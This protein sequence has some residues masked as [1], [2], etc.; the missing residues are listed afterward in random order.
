MFDHVGV[1]VSDY[2]VSKPFY[3]GTLA[4]L[5]YAVQMEFAE[6]KTAGF[7]ADGVPG[8]FWISERDPLTTGT[9]VAFQARDRATV[10]A[11]HA[12]GLAAGGTDNGGPGVREHY[13]PTYYSA[14]VLDPD[15]NNVEAVCHTAS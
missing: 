13:H 6:W 8:H 1:N 15:G 2:G 14:F 12:A 11:F 4:P 5:G 9:H 3:E 7:G 10:D